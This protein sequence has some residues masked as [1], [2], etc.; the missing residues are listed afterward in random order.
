MRVL[1]GWCFAA[2]ATLVLSAATWLLPAHAADTVKIGYSE[3][4]SGVFAQVGDQGIKSI[5]YAVDGITLKLQKGE[6]QAVL[7]V[8]QYIYGNEIATIAEMNLAIVLLGVSRHFY[9]M[10]IGHEIPCTWSRTD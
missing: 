4:L 6:V 7:P 8:S 5:Q 9:D 10:A 3:A 1:G 2:L